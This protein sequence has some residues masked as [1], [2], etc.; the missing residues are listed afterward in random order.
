MAFEVKSHTPFGGK[1]SLL[2]FWLALV[3]YG[4][5]AGACSPGVNQEGPLVR[6][7]SGVTIV[8]NESPA[9]AEGEE[10]HAGRE[11]ILDLGVMDGDTVYQFFQVAGAVQM[12]DGRLAVG[13]SGTG[14][15]RF[16]D[17]AGTFLGTTQGKGSGP[18]EFE[19]IFF[20]E[21]T[22]GDSLLAYDWRNRRL[23]VMDPHGKFAR[24]FEFT[25]LTTAGGFPIVTEPFP[26]GDILLATDMFSAATEPTVG[27][28]R[29]SAVY[30]IIGPDGETVTTLGSYPGGESY[31]TTDGENWVGG[32]LVFGRFGY[33]AV[34]G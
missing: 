20:L 2:R 24:S 4:M 8:E 30:Y 29:D 5:A 34:S 12:P 33:A 17:G 9:W 26:D 3:V 22:R 18:G 15:I 7:S 21:K 10:W 23:S 28:K 25:I 13:N 32:G 27:A 14:E 31:E 19:D 16:Y 6:D 11:P 1:P